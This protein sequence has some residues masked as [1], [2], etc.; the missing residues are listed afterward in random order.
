MFDW[1]TRFWNVGEEGILRTGEGGNLHSVR[2]EM[3]IDPSITQPFA[4]FKGAED[5]QTSYHSRTTPLLRTELKGGVPRS[6][7]ISPL[8]GVKPIAR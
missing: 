3:F 1:V 7:D 2:S 4:P 8:T 6:I 5:N